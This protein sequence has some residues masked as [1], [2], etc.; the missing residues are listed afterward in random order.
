MGLFDASSK[1]SRRPA[2]LLNTDVR[3]LFKSE[4]RL[5][6]EEFLDEMRAMLFKT[7]MGYEPAEDIVDEVAT[8]IRGPRGAHS[9]T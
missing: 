2:K 6:D 3:D 8:T 1:V 4:G 7:D 9:R 5:V